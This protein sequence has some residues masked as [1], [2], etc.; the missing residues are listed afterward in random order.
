MTNSTDRL[1]DK[2]RRGS[3][4]MKIL[5]DVIYECSLSGSRTTTG[6]GKAPFFAIAA[7]DKMHATTK[8][9][10]RNVK[11]KGKGREVVEFFDPTSILFL[12]LT[13]GM[14]PS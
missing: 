2:G 7:L 12:P 1:R 5:R 3:K 14:D 13:S 10:A 6:E 4:V 9:R 8:L 11:G